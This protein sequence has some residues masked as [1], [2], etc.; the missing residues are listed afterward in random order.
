MKNIAPH[1]LRAYVER[2]READ[3]LIYWALQIELNDNLWDGFR[4]NRD[5]EKE[6][7]RAYEEFFKAY[8]ARHLIHDAKQE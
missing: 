3:P 8:K 5:D 1:D 6:T 4:H 2:H 7:M